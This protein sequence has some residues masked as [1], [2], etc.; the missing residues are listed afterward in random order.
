MSEKI[1]L[2]ELKD[3]VFTIT[4]NHSKANAFNAEMIYACQSAFKQA[5]QD[6][7]IRV[8]LLTGSG[9]IFS[10]GQDLNE[11]T[12]G[13]DLSFRKHL[14]KTYNPLVLQIRQLEKPV[15]AAING[16][17]AGAALGI[18]LACDLRIASESSR[19]TVGFNGI[20]LVPDS[21][22]SLLLPAIIG[23]G[24]ATEATFSNQAIS[25]QQALDWGMVNKLAPPETLLEEVQAL[26]MM[27]AMGPTNIYG[28]TKK[29]FNKAILPNLEEV[30]D[31]EA[32]LQ[33]IAGK[34][35][36]HKEGLSAFLEKRF[37]DYKNI[38]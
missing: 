27:L 2:T 6:K 11:I 13:Q 31:Y 14:L 15:L 32:D 21:A 25:A 5:A 24:R 4:L 34:S 1:V 20:G 37:P 9:K 29:S 12:K 35:T 33:E 38:N 18:A 19:F 36:E 30:L 7:D 10:A 8:V 16:P 28:L 23:L 17:V 3:S 26:A 22:V